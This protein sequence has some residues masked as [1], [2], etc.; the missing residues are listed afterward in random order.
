[1]DADVIIALN[2]MDETQKLGIE[3]D[4]DKLSPAIGAKVIPTIATKK[5]GIE[6]INKSVLE[7]IKVENNRLE[8]ESQYKIDYGSKAEEQIEKIG[9]LKENGEVLK[10]SCKMATIKLLED[11]EK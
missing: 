4:I 1:M 9:I 8:G 6:K 7:S 5:Q 2:M 11:D 3:I 10:V